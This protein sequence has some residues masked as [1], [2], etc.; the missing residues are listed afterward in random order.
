M[1]RWLPWRNSRRYNRMDEFAV[2]LVHSTSH[3]IHGERVLK[4]AG[5]AVKLIPTPRHLSSDCG[6][7]LRIAM[8]DR[9]ASESALRAAGVPVDRIESLE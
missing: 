7:A 1:R 5:V 3:A 6:S 2:I 8:A 9:A 4:K